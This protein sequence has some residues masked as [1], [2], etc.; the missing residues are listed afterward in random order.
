MCYFDTKFVHDYFIS[1]RIDM[2]SLISFLCYR[3]TLSFAV[4]AKKSATLAIGNSKGNLLLYNHHSSKYGSA[5]SRW[6]YASIY[7]IFLLPYRKV[8]VI[9]KHTK[10]IICGA[11]NDKDML[12][13]G[14]EDQL[15]T[16]SNP[17]GDTVY[18][19]SCTG[20]PSD[21][22]FAEMKEA[23][24]STAGETTVSVMTILQLDLWS[25]KVMTSS[26]QCYCWSKKSNADQFKRTTKSNESTIPSP[27]WQHHAIRLV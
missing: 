17:E 11:F 23:E 12:A 26:D 10:R 1:Y 8:P 9:G 21:I 13:L 7:P 14:S 22:R 27:I 4:W 20:E 18:S 2:R 24:R 15:I 19:F 6:L 25:S 16:V 3:D 5:Y